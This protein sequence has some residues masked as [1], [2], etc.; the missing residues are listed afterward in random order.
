MRLNDLITSLQ[1]ISDQRGNPEICFADHN[2][3]RSHGLDMVFADGGFV[4]GVVTRYRTFAPLDVIESPR[5][6]YPEY[7]AELRALPVEEK[8]LLRPAPYKVQS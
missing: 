1:K 3:W 4:R 5:G 7:A 6:Y 2:D 8:L